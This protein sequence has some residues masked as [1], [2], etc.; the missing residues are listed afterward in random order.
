MSKTPI[1]MLFDGVTWTPIPEDMPQDDM[2]QDADSI[3]CAT[4][5]GIWNFMGMEIR[6]YRLSTGQAVIHADDMPKVLGLES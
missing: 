5:S 6:V 3:P 2:P 4:H 1:E